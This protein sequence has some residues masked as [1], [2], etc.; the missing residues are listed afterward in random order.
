MSYNY[1]IYGLQISSSR[2]IQLLEEHKISGTDI[3]FIWTDAIEKTPYASASWQRIETK[4]LKNRKRIFYFY[5]EFPEGKI[6]NL[7][8]NNRSSILS[9]ITSGDK[10]KVWIIYDKKELDSNL[11]SYFVGL[12]MGCILRL[13][14]MLCLHA[15]AVNIDGK[16]ILFVGK[17]RSGKS[18]TAAAFS[19]LGYKV[20]ADDIAAIDEQPDGWYIQHG[21]PKVR[22]REQPLALLH[23]ADDKNF[24]PVYSNYDSWYS[25][26]DH[27]FWE[28]A[29]PLGA[30]YLLNQVNDSNSLP[31]VT[32]AEA[33]G[34][35]GLHKNTFANYLITPDLRKVEFEQLGRIISKIPV[36]N[37]FYGQD[38]QL[39]NLQCQTVLDDLKK[40]II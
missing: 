16:A 6:F 26:I 8:F 40:M 23:S 9:L 30:I 39:V 25:D 31:Y 24:S 28:S 15:S 3:E 38:V 19:R 17:K 27:N 13:K 1:L 4:E 33:G 2:R 22:L 11:D 12:V 18:T 37:L 36:R 29:L 35:I 14:G 10:R 7:T 20:L 32:S 21:Y 34:L 5:S